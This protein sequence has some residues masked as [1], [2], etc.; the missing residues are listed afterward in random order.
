MT[1]SAPAIPAFQRIK[2]LIL[3]SIQTG[4]WKQGQAIPSELAL[5]K[6]FGVS[7]MTVNRA[8]REL[9]QE[10]VLTRVQGSGTFVAQKKYQ[11]TLVQINSI[12][13]EIRARGHSHRSE[14]F[15]L[16]KMKAGE[17]LAAQFEIA[18]NR[19]LFHSVMVHFENDEPIQVE[20]RWVN[21]SVAPEY[22]QQDFARTTPNEYLLENVPLQSGQYTVEAL[23]AP[24]AI[25]EML[26]IKKNEACLVLQRTTRSMN[27]VATRATMWHPGARYQFSGNI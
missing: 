13:K 22:L 24:E 5:A 10:Q 20:E 25:A 23:P 11:T 27:Q 1:T 15:L 6:Q 3:E 18:P 2:N 16:E 26:H 21:P 17:A 7:R 19:Y 14:L 9:T 4:V 8:M 12:A